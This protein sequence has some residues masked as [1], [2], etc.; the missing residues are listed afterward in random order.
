ML[1]GPEAH[2]EPCQLGVKR[3]PGPEAGSWLVFTLPH[4]PACR[5]G[6]ARIRLKVHPCLHPALGSEGARRVCERRDDWSVCRHQGSCQIVVAA[7]EAAKKSNAAWLVVAV[8]FEERVWWEPPHL[9][10]AY[11]PRAHLAS[12]ESRACC[13]LHGWGPQQS[14]L[15]AGIACLGIVGAHSF[16]YELVRAFF[17][18]PSSFN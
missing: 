11:P 16:C 18:W 10:L 12:L 8:A 5:Q 7:V 14:I 4:S 17:P 9:P 6:G 1:S 3:V 15:I 13:H 2:L